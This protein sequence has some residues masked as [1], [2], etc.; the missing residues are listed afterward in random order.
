M[1]AAIVALLAL[2]ALLLIVLIFVAARGVTIMLHIERCPNC[3]KKWKAREVP[4]R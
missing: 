4:I 1:N 3:R 2:I